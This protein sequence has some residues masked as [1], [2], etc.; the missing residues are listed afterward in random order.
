[1]KLS[2]LNAILVSGADMH[3]HAGC[4]HIMGAF[5]PILHPL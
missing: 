4:T 3:R 2:S 1:M 5:Y